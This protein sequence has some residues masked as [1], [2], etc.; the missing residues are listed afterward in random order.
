MA[1]VKQKLKFNDKLKT[2]EVEWLV[3]NFFG[4]RACIILP[5]ISWGMHFGHELDLL[6]VVTSGYAYEVE[7]K[8]SMSDLKQDSL[9]RHKHKDRRNRIKRLYFAVPFYMA[10]KAIN[11]IPEHAGLLSVSYEEVSCVKSPKDNKSAVK[12]NESDYKSMARMATIRYWNIKNKYRALKRSYNEKLQLST[13][14]S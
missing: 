6:V 14:N 2:S 4:H 1:I 11:F 3:G 5:N 12:L 9:K 10:E 7:I 13:T 8:V